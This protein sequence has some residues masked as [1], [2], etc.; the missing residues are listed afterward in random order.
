LNLPLIEYRRRFSPAVEV[1]AAVFATVTAAAA[2]VTTLG[3]PAAFGALVATAAAA[4]V[5]MVLS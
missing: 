1:T 2:T 3:P 4:E 5:S